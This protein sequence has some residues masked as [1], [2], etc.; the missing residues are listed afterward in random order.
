MAQATET[1][2]AFYTIPELMARWQVGRTTI[3]REIERGRLKRKHIGG[4]VRFAAE[5]VAEY[6]LK[7]V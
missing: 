2:K 4:Q 5:D 3:Y 6:E 7:S 1:E